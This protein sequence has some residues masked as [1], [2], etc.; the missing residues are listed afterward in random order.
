MSKTFIS[1][2]AAVIS[3]IN[4]VE[5]AKMREA[6]ISARNRI[7]Q[8]L[9]GPRSGRTYKVPG[10]GVTY[11]ASRPGEYPAVRLGDLKGS[12]R[13]K[14]RKRTFVTDAIVGTDQEHGVHLE[15]K[16]GVGGRPWL[17]RSLKE[18]K[19]ETKRILGRRWF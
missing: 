8:N 16:S 13:W 4:T 14:M 17:E 10:T 3:R 11:T 6:A 12:I 19:P 18:E 5:S 1:G 15:K 2:V 7:V 9:S